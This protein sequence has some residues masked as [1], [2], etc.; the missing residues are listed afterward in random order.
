LNK[1]SRFAAP[2]YNRLTAENV[3]HWSG[4]AEYADADESSAMFALLR[5]FLSIRVEMNYCNETK[6]KKMQT[7]LLVYLPPFSTKPHHCLALILSSCSV[8][9]ALL[10]QTCDSGNSIL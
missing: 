5:D 4:I 1:K 10:T 9:S 3:D 2:V 7:K 6:E 8:W